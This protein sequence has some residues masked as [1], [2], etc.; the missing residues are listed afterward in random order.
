[1]EDIFF[2]KTWIFGRHF[3]LTFKYLIWLLIKLEEWSSLVILVQM[4]EN[5]DQNN[6]E[7]ARGLVKRSGAIE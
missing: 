7:Y 2:F 5:T 4:Q 3:I 1:M 6:S